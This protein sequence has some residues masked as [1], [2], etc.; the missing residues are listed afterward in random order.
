VRDF[1]TLLVLRFIQAVG[2]A[3]LSVIPPTI[4]R[5]RFDGDRMA[6]LQSMITV[7]FM[8]VPMLAPTLGQAVMQVLGWRWI[9][10]AWRCWR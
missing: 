7:V 10:G 1:E 3:G 5:D 9:F 8:V 4:I 2:S 6:R